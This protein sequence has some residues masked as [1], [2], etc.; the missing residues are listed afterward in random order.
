[1]RTACVSRSV[2]MN[3]GDGLRGG[4][5]LE[6]ALRIAQA[7]AEAG[8]SAL[9]PSGGF[10]SGAPLYKLRG[11]RLE[12]AQ[13][14]SAP[15]YEQRRA[16]LRSWVWPSRGASWSNLVPL[17]LFLLKGAHRIRDALPI[18]VGYVGGAHS[19]EQVEGLITEGFAFVQ[20][21]R[22]TIHD[23]EF[24]RR[25]ETG[26]ADESDCDQCNRCVAVMSVKGVR[27]VSLAEDRQIDAER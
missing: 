25:L 27:C 11:A 10:T 12:R 26:E 2:R 6:Q 22:R 18:P 13:D 16:F 4:L 19:R 15:W 8:T 21:G 20:L 9:V 23:P 3:Q 17:P 24:V 5:K 14:Q 7:F 1:M